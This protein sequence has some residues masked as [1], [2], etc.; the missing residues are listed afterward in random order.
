LSALRSA[1][2]RTKLWFLL[3]SGI[4]RTSITGWRVRGQ[5][6]RR[7]CGRRLFVL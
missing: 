7:A 3:S 2:L 1:I 5:W 6:R 4:G